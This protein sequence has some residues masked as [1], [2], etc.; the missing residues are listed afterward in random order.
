MEY[1]IWK[2]ERNLK[3]SRRPKGANTGLSAANMALTGFI[4]YLSSLAKNH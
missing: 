1:S 2:L 3:G 4:F